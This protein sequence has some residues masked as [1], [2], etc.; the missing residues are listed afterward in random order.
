[1]KHQSVL[2]QQRKTIPT[3]DKF[4]Q[5]NNNSAHE[6]V[7]TGLRAYAPFIEKDQYLICGVTI[8]E[9]IS[10]QVHVLNLCALGNNPVTI[11]KEFI[12]EGL[13]RHG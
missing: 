11:V 5:I 7:L 9:Y 8:V 13:P 10:P 12:G 6:Y 3:R 2:P 1:M 4:L